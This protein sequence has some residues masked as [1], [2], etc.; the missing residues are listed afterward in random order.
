VDLIFVDV[1]DGIVQGYSF[2]FMDGWIEFINPPQDFINCPFHYK[3][4]DGKFVIDEIKLRILSSKKTNQELIQYLADTDWLVLRH[5][6]QL[7]LGLETSLS[8]DEFIEI[9]RKRQESRE[10]V[11]NK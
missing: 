8:N 6:D 10:M 1:K 7:E 9:L 2:S 5:R 11:V 3:Y 4:I